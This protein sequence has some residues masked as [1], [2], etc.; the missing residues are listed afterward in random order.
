MSSF[1]E[2]DERGSF[3][4]GAKV[5]DGNN[6]EIIMNDHQ[7]TWMSDAEKNWNA[8]GHVRL[9]SL[10]NLFDSVIWDAQTDLDYANGSYTGRIGVDGEEADP[11][12]LV[13]GWGHYGRGDTFW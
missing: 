13:E 12:L 3:G 5:R 2:L 4:I 6:T 9:R 1:I 11:L 8:E 7:V 10:G